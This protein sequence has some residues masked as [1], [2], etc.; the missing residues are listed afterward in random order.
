MKPLVGLIGSI[1]VHTG[2]TTLVQRLRR[3][4]GVYPRTHGEY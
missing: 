2:N 1:P 4:L 3:S